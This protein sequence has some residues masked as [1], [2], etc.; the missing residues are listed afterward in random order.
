MK[1]SYVKLISLI[2]L[3]VIFITNTGFS[4]TP[5]LECNGNTASGVNATA[6]G[7]G[8]VAS[9]D[10][11]F[12]AGYNNESSGYSSISMGRLSESPGAYS[13]ALG[14]QNF[15]N[16]L[17]FAFGQYARANAEQ[18]LAIGRYVE[19]NATGSIA[20]GS[21]V[22]GLALEN[23]ISNS[24]MIGFNS[25]SPTLFVGPTEI[26][27]SFGK[28]GIGT[29]SPRSEL[30]VNGGLTC[31]G[32]AMPNGSMED[33]YVLTSNAEG[34]ADWAPLPEALW[35][36]YGHS[37]NIFRVAGFVGIGT[38]QPTARLQLGDR[39]AFN[40]LSE[41]YKTIAY[42]ATYAYERFYHLV[43]GPASMIS[44]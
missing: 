3:F 43:N 33:G 8:N 2:F 20:L 6:V 9:G 11:S 27:S 37:G 17:S 22:S 40:D 19:A 34:I 23:N 13:V 44:F 4:Q 12:S 21:S 26:G 18:S 14:S 35:E 10:Y 15:A 1:T 16:N 32:F 36:E 28:V 7:L 41:G 31:K 24:L 38:A 25:T 42:N 29:S 5:C 39:W 30:E